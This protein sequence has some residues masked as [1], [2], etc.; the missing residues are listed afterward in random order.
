MKNIVKGEQGKNL[1]LHW[2]AETGS[3]GEQPARTTLATGDDRDGALDRA[4]VHH[5]SFLL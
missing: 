3:A 4:P 1:A 2:E 5:P